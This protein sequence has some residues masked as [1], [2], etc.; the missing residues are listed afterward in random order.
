[1]RFIETDLAGSYVV[2]PEPF[3]DD[4]GNFQ[5]VWCAREFSEAGIGGRPAQANLSQN[6]RAGTLRG[7]H[8][9]LPPAAETKLV[10]CTRG[11]V[12]DVIVDLR[13]DSP[14]FLRHVGVE[15]SATNRRALW[16][17]ELFAHGYLTL[18]D[19]SDTLY[20]VG[21]F[22]APGQEIGLRWD[23][24]AL[25]IAWPRK[26]TTISQKDAS[27]PDLDPDDLAG[28]VRA[29]VESHHD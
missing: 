23:D 22:Y 2:E 19:E 1:M 7:L 21:S 18:A 4:R 29:A 3:E 16:V 11:A 26:A 17:P 13:P 24:P 25:A 12:W 20:Q 5:R 14:T 9:Q 28:R 8:L 27:W 10:R 15:L 6:H